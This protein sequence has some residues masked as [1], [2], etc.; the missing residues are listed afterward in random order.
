MEP[1]EVV[2]GLAALAHGVRLRAYRALMVAG[3]AGLSQKALA[4]VVGVSPSNLAFHLKELMLA[5]LLSREQAGQFVTYRAA[6]ERMADLLVYLTDNC[7]Q[8][9]PCTVNERFVGSRTRSD[10]GRGC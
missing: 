9:E 10:E 2:Q 5:G 4:E 8:G 7:C 3:S 1:S 6:C